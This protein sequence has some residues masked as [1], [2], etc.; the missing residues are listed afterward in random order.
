MISEVYKSAFS[1]I[2]RKPLRL[3]GTSILASIVSGWISIFFG[4]LPG[5]ALILNSMLTVGGCM[6]YLHGIHGDEI[7]PYQLFDAFKSGKVAGRTVK[8]MLYRSLMLSLWL[9]IPIAGPIIFIVRSYRYALTPYILVEEEDGD[10]FEAYKESMNRTR[11]YCGKM[12]LADLIVILGTGI[13]EGI[14]GGIAAAFAVD[15]SYAVAGLFGFFAVIIGLILFVTMPLFLGLVHAAFYEK[16]TA[17]YKGTADPTSGTP[18]A[19]QQSYGQPYQQPYG[20]TYQQPYGQT[21]QQPYGQTR[22]QQPNPQAYQR[23]PYQ[24][25]NASNY[26]APT[27]PGTEVPSAPRPPQT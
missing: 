6:V 25:P 11:G 19:Y 12:F 26:A 2:S 17:I 14:F 8:G 13:I 10:P 4:P 16:I 18:G 3:W 15:G 24:A 9:L 23:Q 20:Q 21:N 7:E 1:I 27:A 22:Q 5:A